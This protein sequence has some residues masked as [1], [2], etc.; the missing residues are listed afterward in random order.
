[1]PKVTLFFSYF[2]NLG[3]P[4]ARA[5]VVCSAPRYRHAHLAADTRA[6]RRRAL[7]KLVKKM[8][9]EQLNEWRVKVFRY[10][11]FGLMRLGAFFIVAPLFK[12]E[13]C[14]ALPSARAYLIAFAILNVVGVPL[15]LFNN[16]M[17]I[18]KGLNPNINGKIGTSESD[19]FSFKYKLSQVSTA[20]YT[21]VTR[22]SRRWTCGSA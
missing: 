10:V 22:S 1:L 21:R 8:N 18:R 5:S 2:T 11:V 19:S 7:Q 6:S 12:H 16:A 13:H 15:L 20:S 17:R 3:G 4:I 14:S 9:L